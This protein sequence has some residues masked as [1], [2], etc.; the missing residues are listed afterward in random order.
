MLDLK[1]LIAEKD[2]IEPKL[3]LREP[4]IDLSNLESLDANRREL[5]SKVETL[6]ADKNAASKAIGKIVKD[7]GDVDAAKAKVLKLSGEI[8]KLDDKLKAVEDELNAI[9][10]VLPN[11]P[12]DETPLDLD[13]RNN[14]VVNTF[15]IAKKPDKIVSSFRDH[16][17]LG[18]MCDGLDFE[19]AA[20]LA[21][22]NFVIYKNGLARLEWG[23]ISWL[24]D[25][26]TRE[27]GHSLIIPP[28]LVNAESMY[29]SAQYPK[30]R[31]QSYFIDTDDLALIPTGEVPLLNLF[32]GE[33][34]EE[35]DLPIN[36]CAFTPCFRREAGTYG[37]D[38][39]GLI[40][41]HQFHKVEMFSFTL[42][43]ESN[44]ELDRMTQCAEECVRQLGIPFRTT[45]LVSGDLAT[46]AA[47]TYDIEA[48]MPSQEKYYEVSSCSNCTDYQARRGNIRFR[49]EDSKKLEFV[50][51]L[52][53]SALAT[54]RLML[55]IMEHN[56][57][58][59]GSIE[60][61]E[62]LWPFTGGLVEI[63]PVH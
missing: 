34:L 35:A 56:Q 49:R 2:E 4:D 33:K 41:M 62:I 32:R 15:G 52:N 10:V 11:I 8:E 17:E 40:R 53:G 44:D 45:L 18:L 3:K 58:E 24:I 28:Y 13:K 1:R 19:R 23:L 46:Q 50:H 63:R 6:K 9:I 31:D 36:L 22:N 16:I 26:N 55:S 30:F 61:P 5:I 57:R 14:E 51:T 21:G 20:K 29:S 38:E 27:F 37:R 43:D 7:G 54:S 47:K 39:R 60:V 12:D 42:P 59:D 25:M 48:W